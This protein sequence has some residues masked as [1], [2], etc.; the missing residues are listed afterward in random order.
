MKVAR[1]LAN[2]VVSHHN[3]VVTA[4]CGLRGELSAYINSMS[5]FQV[6]DHPEPAVTQIVTGDDH[7]D[8][9]AATLSQ[10]LNHLMTSRRAYLSDDE[11]SED[12]DF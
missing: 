6:T 11:S 10:A 7:K 2:T 3:S 12:S 9:L 1:F 8:M 5:P 4:S